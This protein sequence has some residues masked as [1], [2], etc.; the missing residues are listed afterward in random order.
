M[1][2]NKKKLGFKYFH[3]TFIISCL[4]VS[5][6][7]VSFL[8]SSRGE[9]KRRN[10]FHKV[11]QRILQIY[12]MLSKFHFVRTFRVDFSPK[13]GFHGVPLNAA[14]FS[15]TR[16]KYFQVLIS[17]RLRNMRWKGLLYSCLLDSYLHK[18]TRDLKGEGEN[19]RAL[20]RC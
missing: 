20:G 10:S 3:F 15:G 12:T 9:K 7:F 8:F 1:A 13:I 11:P 14:Q 4:M 5:Q 16:C 2:K 17:T 18:V 19:H 6:E